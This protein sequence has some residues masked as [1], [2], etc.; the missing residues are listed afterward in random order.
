MT[1][2][3]N[4]GRADAPKGRPVAGAQK[5]PGPAAPSAPKAAAPAP[6][7]SKGPQGG[8]PS[9]APAQVAPLIRRIDWLAAAHAFAIVGVV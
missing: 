5:T 9:P 6:P 2:G 1:N 7:A 3:K 4:S 8:A